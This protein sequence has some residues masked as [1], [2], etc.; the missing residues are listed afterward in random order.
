MNKTTLNQILHKNATCTLLEYRIHTALCSDLFHIFNY[1]DVLF[2]LYDFLCT[3]NSQWFLLFCTK[4]V[5][6][7][8]GRYYDN[9]LV[10]QTRLQPKVLSLERLQIQVKVWV[11]FEA[12]NLHPMID[13]VKV[14]PELHESSHLCE[15]SLHTKL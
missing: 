3:M 7:C 10:T 4:I 9:W 15:E 6:L 1:Q 11:L 14:G 5:I 12:G 8:C 13:R 2:I